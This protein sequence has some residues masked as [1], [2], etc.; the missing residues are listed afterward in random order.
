MECDSILDKSSPLS[1]AQVDQVIY[2]D[3]SDESSSNMSD[4][5]LDEE[6]RMKEDVKLLKHSAKQPIY[7]PEN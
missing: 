2:A 6:Q 5:S 1:H 4:D 7:W 3:S